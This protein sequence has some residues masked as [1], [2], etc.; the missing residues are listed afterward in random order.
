[1]RLLGDK[2]EARRLAEAAGVPVVPGYAG[3][4]LDDA[5]LLREARRLGSPLLVK[6][7]AGGGGRGMRAVRPT[8]RA[9]RGARG[10]PARGGRPPS[11]T[12]ACSWSGG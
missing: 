7:A 2:V 11:A 3:V 10:R 8:G 4:D 1:M 9:G 5:T 6:A 12:T